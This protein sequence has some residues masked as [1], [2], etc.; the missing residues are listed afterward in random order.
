[1][2][3]GIW[4][5]QNKLRPGAYINFEAAGQAQVNTS[6]RGIVAL[7][8][9]LS[10]GGENSIIELTNDDLV[11]GNSLAK[12]GF[13]QSDADALLAN[14]ALQ[15]ATTLKLYNL[16]TG[17]TRATKSLAGG[18]VI[19]AKYPGTFGNTIAILI[20]VA[21][22]IYTIETYANGYF[23]DRQRVTSAAELVA[24]D[25]VVFSGTNVTLEATASTLLTGGT[26]GTVAET[27]LA[28]CFNDLKATKFHA[29]ALP[30]MEETD[31]AAAIAYARTMREDEGKYIQVVVANADTANADYEGVINVVNGVTLE[32]DTTVSAV[33]FTAWVAGAT[34]G[35]DITASLTGKIVQNAIGIVGNLSNDD[36]VAGLSTGKFM[37]SLNQ[38]GTVKVEKDINSLH[39]FSADKS[40]MFSK[41]RI[42]RELDE[43]GSAV[44]DIWETTYLGKVTNNES[45]RTLFKSSIINYL[46]DLQNRGAINEFDSGSVVVAAGDDV[47][48]VIAS[49]AV[50]PLDSMEFLY[51][52][53]TI[54]Q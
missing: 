51:M 15:N 30:S 49:I 4:T 17:G 24:N 20:T 8:T 3:G 1:M 43:I 45:G 47:D 42:M 2:A 54:S 13:V 26:N 19:T 50:K 21:D 22:N 29:L 41:N 25:F 10:W 23:V 46:T 28:T 33:Q 9:T 5:S 37:L 12:V 34:A 38:N 16:N 32:D 39:T 11:T 18:L 6:T 48:S 14:L 53:V 35:A 7:P 44:E 40:Y 52:N 36:I 27:A 31:I